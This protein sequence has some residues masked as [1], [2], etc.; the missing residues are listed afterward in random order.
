MNLYARLCE[1]LPAPLVDWLFILV[2]A[3]LIVLV[4]LYSDQ[5]FSEFAYLRL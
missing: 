4:V 3:L 1:H 2:R 5:R